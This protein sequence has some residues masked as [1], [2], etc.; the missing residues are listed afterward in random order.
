MANIT[1][2]MKQLMTRD[3]DEYCIDMD[4]M[5]DRL[6]ERED[7]TYICK[8]GDIDI[9]DG[10][11]IDNG[12]SLFMSTS[13][14]TAFLNHTSLSQV[15]GMAGGGM[16]VINRLSAETASLA[17]NEL[18]RESGANKKGYSVNVMDKGAYKSIRSFYSPRYERVPDVEVAKHFRSLAN[19]YGYEP[20]GT[21]AGKR[22]GLAPIKE[23]CTGL[24]V[25]ERDIFG[26]LANERDPVEIDGGSALY[27][28]MI[29]GN[30][31]CKTST[32][33]FLHCYY[34]YICGNMILWNVGYT[35]ESKKKHI[36]TPRDVLIGATEAF[37][38]AE[39][40]QIST[41]DKVYGLVKTAQR[42]MFANSIKNA[43]E[44]LEKYMNKKQASNVLE[45]IEH[46][47]A[48][49]VSPLSYYGI[50]SAITLYSQTYSNANE[51]MGL[52]RISGKL[53]SS[54]DVI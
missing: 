39:A 15:C 40:D 33:F 5:V 16:N 6:Q 32:L 53:M 13:V 30:S 36:G 41:R 24:Y 43:K 4:H 54:V 47:R 34:S 51:M 10:W 35:N 9:H 49:P 48:Y 12:E 26:F 44:K 27:S 38:K 2:G 17:L 45:F 23:D 46:P 22:G 8:V 1:V 42:T 19:N 21:F 11:N 18:L 20:A 37:Q 31:E 25:G 52:N 28:A 14:G 29:F 3:S 50:G 7:N